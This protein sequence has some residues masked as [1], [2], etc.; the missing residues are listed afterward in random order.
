MRKR[1]IGQILVETQAITEEDLAAA[2]AEQERSGRRLGEILIEQGRT[3]W[4]A[5][6]RAM[7]EQ[8]LDIQT[9]PSE[10]EPEAKPSPDPVELVREMAEKVANLPPVPDPLPPPEDPERDLAKAM[11]EQVANLDAPAAGRTHLLRLTPA[12]VSQQDPETKLQTIE[13]LLKERQ[14]AFIELLTTA[15]NLRSRVSR[16]EDQLAE[17]TRELS[18]LRVTRSA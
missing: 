14:R 13:A 4:L 2:L 18:R 16:L 1:P 11:A 3:S 9:A 12:G 8:V 17:Q 6:A 10:P 15:E 5:L 7:A